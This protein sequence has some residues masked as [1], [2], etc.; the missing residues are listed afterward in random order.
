[1]ASITVSRS[2]YHVSKYKR[3]YQLFDAW[4]QLSEIIGKIQTKISQSR[5]GIG[6]KNAL[7]GACRR[8]FQHSIKQGP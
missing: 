4:I 6:Q 2:E 1:M 7:T 5:D 3:H 8:S